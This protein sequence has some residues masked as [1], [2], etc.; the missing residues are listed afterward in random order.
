MSKQCD[1]C[2]WFN[3]RSRMFECRRYP[4]AYH[5]DQELTNAPKGFP[6]VRPHDW[7]G[8][9]TPTEEAT[10]AKLAQFKEDLETLGL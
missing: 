8:E 6:Y 4:P 1:N 3:D 7:C 9:W 10:K 5:A 2:R